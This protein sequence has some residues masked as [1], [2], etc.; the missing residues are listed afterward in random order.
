MKKKKPAKK[1]PRKNSVK[2]T[3]NLYNSIWPRMLFIVAVCIALLFLLFKST[4]EYASV[5]QPL[6]ESK[7]LATLISGGTLLHPQEETTAEF[8]GTNVEP[9]SLSYFED[10]VSERPDA[11]LAASTDDNKR[12]EVDLSSQK[13]YA[14]EGDSKVYEFTVSTGK[15]YPTPTGEFRIWSKVRSQK[16]SGGSKALRTY[17]YLPNVP[18]VMFFYNDEI[19]KYRGF[20]LHGT[21]WHSNFGHPMS[22]GCVNMR[23]EDAKILY[24]WANPAVTNPKAWSTLANDENPG[25]RVIIY[26]VT[27]KS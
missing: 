3:L 10:V 11:V 23:T 12:I 1:S 9:P 25:T 19:G 22:H 15:W 7:D 16:M 20:G 27:P 21:Y 26:G 17:Y 6:A 24:E 5:P 2:K 8:L 13:V 18:Y 4:L 14:F